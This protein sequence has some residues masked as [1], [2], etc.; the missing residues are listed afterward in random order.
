M[1]GVVPREV[2]SAEPRSPAEGPQG[3]RVVE[4]VVLLGASP[5]TLESLA[6]ARSLHGHQWPRRHAF[7]PSGVLG[8]SKEFLASLQAKEFLGELMIL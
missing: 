5:Q 1:Q 6:S 4:M 2:C 7:G 3:P 8:P